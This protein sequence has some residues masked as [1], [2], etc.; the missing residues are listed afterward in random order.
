MSLV[1]SPLSFFAPLS[2]SGTSVNNPPINGINITV[3]NIIFTT[4]FYFYTTRCIFLLFFSV[5]LL[6]YLA[7]CSVPPPTL[8]PQA[9]VLTVGGTCDE[10]CVGGNPMPGSDVGG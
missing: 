2:C 5:F 4:L 3:F 9:W 6:F 10:Q 1:L 7:I 8:T